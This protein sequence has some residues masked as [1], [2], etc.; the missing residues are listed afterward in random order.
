MSTATIRENVN[1]IFRSLSKEK[2]HIYLPLIVVSMHG[3]AF[4]FISSPGDEREELANDLMIPAVKG[5]LGMFLEAAETCSHEID[6]LT[7][8]RNTFRKGNEFGDQLQADF[9]KG[10]TDVCESI[11]CEIFQRDK[12]PLFFYTDIRNTS[13]NEIEIGEE[14]R[15]DQSAYGMSFEVLTSLLNLKDITTLG[16]DL[17]MPSDKLLKIVSHQH[18]DNT[19]AHLTI[20]LLNEYENN[21]EISKHIDEESK[22]EFSKIRRETEENLKLDGKNMMDIF[23]GS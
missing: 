13:N 18:N 23:F 17:G 1:E 8:A 5:A 9:D 6:S 12:K 2:K 4:P 7:V 19:L 14:K 16:K 22:E 10:S 20:D 15:Y 11:V 3:L 21:E